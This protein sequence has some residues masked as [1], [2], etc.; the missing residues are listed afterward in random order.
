MLGHNQTMLVAALDTTTRLGSLAIVRD[1]R[2]LATRVGDGT[3]PHA[4]RLPGDL[5]DLLGDQGLAVS[6][7]DVFGVAAGPGSFTGLR[8]GLAAVQGL[9]FASGKP[10]VGVSAFEAVAAAVWA[11]QP[12]LADASLAIWLDAQRHEVFAA[13][14]RMIGTRAAGTGPEFE[15]VD[16]PSVATPSVVL[17]RWI[18]EAW[19]GHVTF[20]GDG[21]LT[22]RDIL[23][24]RLGTGLRVIAPTPLLAPAIGRLAEQRAGAGKALPPHAVKPIYVR[25]S[26]AELARDRQRAGGA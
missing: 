21:A 10:V 1:Q 25:R 12:A 20:A 11:D 15:Y 14:L 17:E 22:Y 24:E 4:T 18:G 2:V 8:I 13:V 5:L 19:W 9:A 3:R 26:D 23:S 6:D 7:V 16:D